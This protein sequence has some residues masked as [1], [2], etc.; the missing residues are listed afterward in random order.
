[1]ARA[2]RRRCTTR[3]CRLGDAHAALSTHHVK[4]GQLIAQYRSAI[5]DGRCQ[6]AQGYAHKLEV[7]ARNVCWH[8][9]RR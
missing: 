3:P 8:Q 2:R 7:A 4:I 6:S 1:M 5:R 9:G